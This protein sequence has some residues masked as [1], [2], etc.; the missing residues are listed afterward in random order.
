MRAAGEHTTS[1]VRIGET[2]RDISLRRPDDPAASWTWTAVMRE[3][4]RVQVDPVAAIAHGLAFEAAEANVTTATVGRL[5]L[6]SDMP[7]G[8][9]SVAGPPPAGT[10]FA[11][12]ELPS[13]VHDAAWFRAVRN[14]G[15]HDHLLDHLDDLFAADAVLT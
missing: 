4:R 8:P 7:G 5:I 15:Y 14:A 10:T 11:A 12:P 6:E 2:R 13:L 9:N 3:L 1:A